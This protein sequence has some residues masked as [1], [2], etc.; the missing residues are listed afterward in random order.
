MVYA[1]HMTTHF[2]LFS[3]C[4]HFSKYT[5]CFYPLPAHRPSVASSSTTDMKGKHVSIAPG[6]P[7]IWSL[8]IPQDHSLAPLPS[9]HPH[10]RSGPHSQLRS[11]TST[12]LN[13]AFCHPSDY[14]PPLLIQQMY[15]PA[16]EA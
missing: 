14:V 13:G 12:V 6:V 1:E 5:K 11:H 16:C 7:N 9:P 4:E 15:N 3:H 8:S 2:F 10:T